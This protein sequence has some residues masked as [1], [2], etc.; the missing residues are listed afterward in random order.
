MTNNQWSRIVER[1]HKYGTV[2]MP[3]GDRLVLC[4]NG[5]VSLLDGDDGH[6][7]IST[8]VADRIKHIYV[9]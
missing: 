6:C 7:I 1:L 8:N 4:D 2:K 9:C 5:D 3:D